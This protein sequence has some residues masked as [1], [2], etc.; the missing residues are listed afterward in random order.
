MKPTTN[1]IKEQIYLAI[2][3]AS[4]QW[5][6]RP[7]GEFDSTGANIVAEKLYNYFKENN[8]IEN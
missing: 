1:E 5:N 8:L 2:G 7:S 3:E 4:M 6:P